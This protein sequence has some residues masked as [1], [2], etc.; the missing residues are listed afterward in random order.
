MGVREVGKWG[1]GHIKEATT[2]YP[3][4]F[5]LGGENPQSGDVIG[6]GM[7]L[8]DVGQFL[9][10]GSGKREGGFSI[11]FSWLDLGKDRENDYNG[12]W[13]E[14]MNWELQKETKVGGIS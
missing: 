9:K 2:L 12:Y 10:S 6:R 11:A 3:N 4:Q 1:G 5:S 14:G 8:Q 7:K 13:R